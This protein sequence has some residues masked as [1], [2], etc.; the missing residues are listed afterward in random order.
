MPAPGFPNFNPNAP[1]NQSYVAALLNNVNSYVHEYNL[2]IQ[3]QV[4]K[5]AVFTLGYV[6]DIGK[7]L[8]FY[9][10]A[11]QQFFNAPVG[12]RAFPNLS[13]ITTQAT[14][15][16]SNYNSLQTQFEK[17]MSKGL[18]YRASFTWSKNIS[19]GD[20]AFDGSQPQS[21][22]NF[23][24]ERGLASIH[25]KYLFVSDLLYELPFGRGK[26]F[27]SHWSR[28]VDLLLG[29]W[30]VNG[31]WTWQS[32]LP[33]NI[34]DNSNYFGNER[35]NVVGPLT[36]SGNVNSY[37]N[38]AALAAPAQVLDATGS[39]TGVFVA[40]GNLGRN[41][42]T[43]KPYLDVDVAVFKD[44]SITERLKFQFRGQVYNIANHERWGQPDSNLTDGNFG[45]IT[46]TVLNSERQIELG[47][48]FYC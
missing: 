30:R 15:G 21:S 37:F 40:T 6:G 1:V 8:T 26:S 22:C 17:R 5:D 11:N 31:I 34:T 16:N 19:D 24:A 12:A 44:F 48:R 43:G 20:G 25:Q 45:R 18:Q 38:T 33:F 9:Y 23:A 2:Q 14:R 35:P 4:F 10:D 7:K 42:L 41:V 39:P 47:A 46:S 28:P 13:S 3:R 27:G 29:G 32:G 36:V